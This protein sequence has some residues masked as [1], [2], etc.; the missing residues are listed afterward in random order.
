VLSMGLHKNESPVAAVS[1]VLFDQLGIDKP[2]N[3]LV[4]RL[5]D[6]VRETT[7]APREVTIGM[8]SKILQ[9]FDLSDAVEAWADR[10]SREIVEILS[11]HPVVKR[12]AELIDSDHVW[13]S[14]EGTIAGMLSRVCR[15]L[16]LNTVDNTTGQQSPDLRRKT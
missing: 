4:M 3:I 13:C 10:S 12:A 16:D 15:G 9:S 8:L 2:S 11:K 5:I 6:A 1:R 7:P 14:L